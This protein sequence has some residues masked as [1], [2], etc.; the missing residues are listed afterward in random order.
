M[1]SCTSFCEPKPIASPITPAPASSGAMFTP[2][3]LST[4]SPAT[5]T[6]VSSSVVRSIGSSVRRRA[7]R[8]ACASRASRARCSW[9][10]PLAASQTNSASTSVVPMLPS[11]PTM[12]PPS[13][14][15]VNQATASMPQ[16]WNSTT[17]ATATMTAVSKAWAIGW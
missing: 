11:A 15:L 16:A 4:I 13:A 7:E 5:V 9:M 6:M 12:R 10:P 2:M 1:M 14:P 17:A 3:S 8:A